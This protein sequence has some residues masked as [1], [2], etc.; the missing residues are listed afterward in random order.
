VLPL[1]HYR[2]RDDFIQLILGLLDATLNVDF[3]CLLYLSWG[4]NF[5]LSVEVHWFNCE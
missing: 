5:W 4:L 2:L 3:L 1:N